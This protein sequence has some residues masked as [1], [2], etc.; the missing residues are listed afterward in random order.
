MNIDGWVAFGFVAQAFF[1]LRFVVQWVASERKK[2]SH[3]PHS[4]WYLSIVGGLGLLAYAVHRRDPVFIIGNCFGVF[5][6]LRNLVL[7]HQ[8]KS[9]PS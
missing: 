6:Y 7:I 3:I 2:E 5:I 9:V 1:F 8:K 4:F